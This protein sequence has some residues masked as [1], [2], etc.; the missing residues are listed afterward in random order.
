[1]TGLP[2]TAADPLKTVSISSKLHGD[3]L[4]LNQISL[5]TALGLAMGS[6]S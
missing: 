2:V 5:T 6:A 1:M 4:Q 3:D